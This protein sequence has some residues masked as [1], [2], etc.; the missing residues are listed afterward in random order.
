MEYMS[1]TPIGTPPIIGPNGGNGPNLTHQM[2]CGGV[3]DGFLEL[4]DGVRGR[5][6]F[7]AWR[8]REGCERRSCDL[9]FGSGAC[10]WCAS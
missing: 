9:C 8:R 4:E 2:R 1:G 7:S 10:R 6:V 3:A 5:P